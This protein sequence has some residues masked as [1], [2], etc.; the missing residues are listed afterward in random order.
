MLRARA[1]LKIEGALCPGRPT[2]ADRGS[3][4]AASPEGVERSD[5][6]DAG[7]S[8]VVHR[9]DDSALAPGVHRETAA[10]KDT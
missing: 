2:S 4:R 9:K 3:A 10:L 1:N 8:N 7:C 6:L 5:K